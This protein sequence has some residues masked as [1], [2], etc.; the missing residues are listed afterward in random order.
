ML[1]CK[2]VG[3]GAYGK[4]YKANFKN[5]DET[6]AI[7][8]NFKDINTTGISSIRE[9]NM[10]ALVK[11]H[12]L[13]TDLKDITYENP[14]CNL[15]LTPI[16]KKN[17]F[18]KD[19]SN[20][21]NTAED[22]IYFILEYAPFSGVTFFKDKEKCNAKVGKILVCQLLLAVEYIHSLGITHRDIKPGNILIT[23]DKHENPL[24]KLGDFGLSQSL[25]KACPSTPGVVTFCYR[26][27]E[28][29]FDCTKYDRKSDLWSVGCVMFEIFG[30]NMYL[31]AR[32][33]NA[34]AAL[35]EI[36]KKHP[37][38][39]DPKVLYRY[40]Q[41]NINYK[42]PE[43]KVPFIKQMSIPFEIKNQLL[44]DNPKDIQKLDSLLNGLMDFDD[45]SRIDA[46]IA[47]EKTFLNEFE[48]Y[49][50]RFRERYPPVP[51][52]L[53][54]VKIV[55]CQERYWI[56]DIIENIYNSRKKIEWYRDKILFQAIDLFDRYIEWSFE[57]ET[58]FH[59]ETSNHGFITT[60]HDSFLHFYFCL[61][62]IHKYHCSLK[63]PERW[64]DFAPSAIASE[65]YVHKYID[66]EKFILED[67]IEYKIRAS[68][69]EVSDEY[70]KL[71]QKDIKKL[72][73]EYASLE[74]WNNGSMRALYRK[75][76][77]INL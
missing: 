49:I 40:S 39:I 76:M 1:K 13:V 9:L 71:S 70:G 67:V 50:E 57:R 56:S 6:Y 15:P 29:W 62:F 30:K 48:D 60:K 53:P 16:P 61:Y 41:K 77:N 66:F 63:H 37:K 33:D 74:E 32:C 24:L 28:I 47:L 18:N 20:D 22:G 7:K 58:K 44:S 25:C 14:F 17:K 3:E 34:K 8:R 36:V 4:V 27:P 68:L 52:K 75:L 55:K 45:Y 26:A 5:S 43:N 73:T 35:N 65:E 21:T 19:D 11:G 23:F 42:Q 64:E 69:L 31:K 59:N 72:L 12:P 38:E 2:N 46:T 10:L 51:P 54:V